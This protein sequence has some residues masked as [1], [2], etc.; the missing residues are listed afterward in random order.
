LFHPGGWEIKLGHKTTNPQEKK[1][2]KMVTACFRL[3]FTLCRTRD[4]QLGGLALLSREEHPH[5]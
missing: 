5:G 3:D 1:K 2:R 4:A